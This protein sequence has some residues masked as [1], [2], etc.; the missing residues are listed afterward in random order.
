MRFSLRELSMIDLSN[1]FLVMV[2]SA[3]SGYAADG[4][5]YYKTSQG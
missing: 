5:K 2:K 3:S 1:L 4:N